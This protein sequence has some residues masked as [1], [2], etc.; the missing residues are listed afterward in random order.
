M[1]GLGALLRLLVV[2]AL[3]AVL[4][5]WVRP[6]LGDPRLTP[7]LLLLALLAFAMH[8]R[9]AAGAAAGFLLGL[10]VDAVA[11]TAFGAG[12]LAG[13]AVGFVAGWIRTQFVAD[14]VLVSALFI[15]GAAWVRDLIQVV[16]SNQMAGRALLWQLLA[17][18]P[19]A[20]ATT[21]LCGLVV[22]AVA[23]RW[24]RAART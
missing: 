6:R 12:A 21:A 4:H 3:L 20:A 24:M 10:T 5:F 13:T 16:A 1:K 8:V 22:F 11:P 9:P 18:S 23:G 19:A 14:N 7:D 2:P 17:Y 15:F